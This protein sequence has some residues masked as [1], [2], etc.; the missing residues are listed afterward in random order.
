VPAKYGTMSYFQATIHKPHSALIAYRPVA[1]LG[2][3][4]ELLHRH[5]LCPHSTLSFKLQEQVYPRLILVSVCHK[6]LGPLYALSGKENPEIVNDVRSFI[7]SAECV[8]NL[9]FFF[10]L[11][12]HDYC[13]SF[14]DMVP[15]L[16]D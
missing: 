5:S 4:R 16:S 14:L 12:P 2:K 11:L 8:Y 13:S 1:G 3:A 10:L 9:P 15:I 6:T 7:L